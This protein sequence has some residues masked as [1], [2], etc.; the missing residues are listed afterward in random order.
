MI[1]KR[2]TLFTI[3]F[4]GGNR[5]AFKSF[6]RYFESE[7]RVYSLELSGRGNRVSED[8]MSNLS[9]IVDDLFSQMRDNLNDEYIIYGHSMGG[10]LAYLLTIKIEEQ[11]LLAPSSIIISGRAYPTM[12]PK[13]IRHNLSKDKFKETLRELNGTPKEILEHPELFEFFE[14]ILR[15]DFKAIE[16]YDFK[17]DKI[18]NTKISILYGKE[19][20][21][22]KKKEAKR[23]QEFTNVPI[24]FYQFDGGHFFIFDD[25]SKVCSTISSYND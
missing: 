23:W 17:E 19:E 13:Q 22:F 14:S 9:E 16:S 5:Y 21:G 2:K 20:K 8:L 3:P 6:D 18:V 15:A 25:I 12:R 24:D 7:F 10:L 11:N 4:A 1:K